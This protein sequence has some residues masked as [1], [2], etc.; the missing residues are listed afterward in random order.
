MTLNKIVLDDV[1][2]VYKKGK[3]IAI[4]NANIVVKRGEVLGVIGPNGAGKTSLLKAIAGIIRYSGL[5]YINGYE[6]SH[7]P[8]KVI[9]RILSYAGDM[10][11]P[12][13]LSLTVLDAILTSR[14]PI[15][16]SFFETEEDIRKALEVLEILGIYELKD[17]RLDELSSGEIRKVILAMAL[18]REPK[19]ILLDEPDAHLDM[20]SKIVVSRIIKKLSRRS[21]TIFT[22]HDILFAINTASKIV[23][24]R[25]GEIIGYGTIDDIVKKDL[26]FKTY[27]TRFK[28]LLDP[29]TNKPVPIPS[30]E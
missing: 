17:R 12:E 6:V 21:I 2:V 4:K 9:A 19:V 7:T 30:Y 1:K 25:D 16:E 3:I 13:M 11:I 18:A 5:I 27:N 8:H 20:S 14:Y 10:D 29:D 23:L 24:L 15:S 26:L 28:I 22:T